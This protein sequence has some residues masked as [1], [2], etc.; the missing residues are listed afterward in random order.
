MKTGRHLPVKSAV[1]YYMCGAIN[2]DVCFSRNGLR[3]TMLITLCNTAD[4]S[5]TMHQHIPNGK[6]SFGI[7]FYSLLVGGM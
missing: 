2:A 5:M 3:H 6:R 7:R 4:V 1:L